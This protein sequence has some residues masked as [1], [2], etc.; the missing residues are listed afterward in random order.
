LRQFVNNNGTKSV[1]HFHKRLGKI[2]WDKVVCPEM[3]TF[4]EAITEIKQ[5]REEFWKD[6]KVPGSADTK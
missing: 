3:R 2:M 6:V 1:D 5:L 4:Q